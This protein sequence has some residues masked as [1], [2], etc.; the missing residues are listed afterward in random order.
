MHKKLVDINTINAIPIVQGDPLQIRLLLRMMDDRYRQQFLEISQSTISYIQ[1]TTTRSKN[2]DSL[3]EF[4]NILTFWTTLAKSSDVIQHGKRL[5]NL[6]WR[7]INRRILK[8]DELRSRDLN[9]VVDISKGTECRELQ[10]SGNRRKMQ[11]TLQNYSVQR[12]P[13]K[14]D[15]QQQ[16]QVQEHTGQI[17]KRP[18][19][20]RKTKF[21]YDH[22]LS[23]PDSDTSVPQ[24]SIDAITELKNGKVST[25]N[26][27]QQLG[28][29]PS[30]FNPHMMVGRKKLNHSQLQMTSQR[31]HQNLQHYQ[32]Q[33]NQQL[34]QDHYKHHHHHQSYQNQQK[35]QSL[36][37]QQNQQSHPNHHAHPAENTLKHEK[38][39]ESA[40]TSE[41]PSLFQKPE[42][43]TS[44]IVYSSSSEFDQDS[45]SDWSSLSDAEEEEE[46]DKKPSLNFEKKAVVD[47]EIK[48]PQL[49][50]SLL[51]GMFLDE[52]G[53]SG[54]DKQTSSVKGKRYDSSHRSNAPPTASTLLPTALSTH[55]FLPTTNFQS[56]QS[57]QRGNNPTSR[58]IRDAKTMGKLTSDNVSKMNRTDDFDS[59]NNNGRAYASSIHTQTSSIDIPGIEDKI[60]RDKRRL[61]RKLEAG[62]DGAELPL[63]L[64]DSIQN[65]NK[66]YETPEFI[67]DDGLGV[68][69]KQYGEE[70]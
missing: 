47:D 46:E 37:K 35:Q 34:Q 59:N 33:Q 55:M 54:N 69:E 27:G 50:R 4:D 23:S 14:K 28:Q 62:N 22:S 21:F 64:V 20:F 19:E 2:E 12:L 26:A 42:K 57:T 40:Q 45:D 53:K 38:F 66:L 18:Q 61:E 51:S 25:Q 10:D 70:W 39:V 58:R 17:N 31:S 36:Q 56:Y 49:K 67:V 43:E 15:Q 30:L 48:R 11:K 32:Q 3:V 52:M 16:K 68:V 65:E 13:F 6:S 44:K 9:I 60:E 5:E 63:H 29:V 24:N 8:Q 1:K 41:Q 7:L